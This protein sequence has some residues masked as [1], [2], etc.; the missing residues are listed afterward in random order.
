[1]RVRAR[2][3]VPMALLGLATLVPTQADAGLLGAGRTVQAFYFNGTFANPEGELTD[4]A[5]TSNPTSLASPV[6]YIQGAA[7]G[8]TIDVAD[9]RIIITNLLSGAPFCA[10]VGNVGAACTDAIDGFDFKFTGETIL[11]VTVDPSSAPAFQ[12]ATFGSH[13][14]L[15]LLSSNEIQVDVTG[16]LA[17]LDDQLVLDLSFATTPPPPPPAPEPASVALL[18]AGLAGL[19]AV[20]RRAPRNPT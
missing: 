20:R 8:A 2:S 13:L 1:M 15:Q 11:G 19:G 14:G 6:H 9:T 18:V 17:L 10:P 5:G 3:L 4:P 12:P 16:D 7:D